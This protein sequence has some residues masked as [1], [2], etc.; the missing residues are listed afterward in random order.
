MGCME[1]CDFSQVGGL[2]RPK[3]AI[4]VNRSFNVSTKLSEENSRKRMHQILETYFY[5]L[6]FMD[7]EWILI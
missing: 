7:A 6:L 5:L 1:T 4:Y 2:V 3:I